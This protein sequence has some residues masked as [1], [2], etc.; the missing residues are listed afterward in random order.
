MSVQNVP[1]RAGP[2]V[3]DNIATAFSFTFKVFKESEVAVV[4]SSSTEVWATDQALTLGTD[5]TV[6]L[7][8]DQD[9][10]PGGVVTLAEPLPDG[11]RL[12]ILSAIAPDQ[13]VVLTNHDGF[14]P[15]TLNDVH[16][17]A[18][19]LIQQLLELLGRAVFL[20]A[21]STMTAEELAKRLLEAYDLAQQVVAIA[22][23]I[24]ALGPVAD[25]IAAL[26]PHAEAIGRISEKLDDLLKIDGIIG[27]IEEIEE[28]TQIAQDA[29]DSANAAA[30]KAEGLLGD[31]EG[32]FDE[33]QVLADLTDSY[34]LLLASTAATSAAEITK[35]D[36]EHYY[37]WEREG[38][39]LLEAVGTLALTR[40]TET[41]NDLEHWDMWYEDGLNKLRV[42]GTV[43]L[44][45]AST[46]KNDI[47]HFVSWF[48]KGEEEETKL[49][50]KLSETSQTTKSFIEM[51][52]S[53]YD[54]EIS[55]RNL[56]IR[57]YV[58]KPVVLFIVAGQSNAM[59]Q[60]GRPSIESADWA[61]TYW[62]WKDQSN[63]SLKP[64]RDP[65]Y[66]CQQ[67]SAWPAFGK[68]FFA[69][70]GRKVCILNVAMGGSYVT[71]Y[72]GTN[73]WF[74]DDSILRQEATTEWNAC[75]AA[76]G[77]KGAD[78]E[79]GGMLW[80]QG[81]AETYAT[82]IGST[83]TQLY[84][85]G[86]LDVFDFFRTLTETPTLPIYMSQ[87]GYQVNLLENPDRM[88]GFHNI[89]NAQVELAHENEN[90]FMAF[91]GAKYFARA[92]MMADNIHYDV[93]GY[94][95]VGKAFARFISNNQEF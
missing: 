36:I 4:R 17:K 87:I 68:E 45:S 61:G 70:T 15:E 19:A 94:R 18:V 65:V 20:P 82:V 89:Q 12:T 7:N 62:D 44:Y 93:N 40:S 67:K 73:T 46:T 42:A 13:L 27:A 11:V 39:A 77:T 32:V 54:D 72:G 80:I 34:L 47:E 41:K 78:W 95:V 14:L 88:Q 8:K 71:D 43:A 84:K 64:L 55:K 29:A 1:R 21:T 31:L 2:S 48:T 76:L 50:T 3:G 74:G 33:N 56:L 9:I 10:S 16:D 69:L 85:S 63:K 6:K 91:E 53:E 81:E 79:L 58:E 86:T 22:D 37:C 28:N 30:E 90:V 49:L 75:T 24:R 23:E 25:D 66:R 60:G 52:I 5:Y 57:T 51:S 26:G 38:L 83:T 35:R 59:G 92:N